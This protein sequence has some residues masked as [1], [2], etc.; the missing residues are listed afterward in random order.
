MAAQ[1]ATVKKSNTVSQP[2]VEAPAAVGI[3]M[4]QDM[5][6][7]KQRVLGKPIESVPVQNSYIPERSD[8]EQGNLF[9]A[10]KPA[11]AQVFAA[12]I[13]PTTYPGA[14]SQINSKP[15][16]NN[17]LSGF[18]HEDQLIED[19]EAQRNIDMNE[20]KNLLG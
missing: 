11:N 7:N 2:V 20:L 8:E 14:T 12:K 3:T 19:Q 16:Y 9:A 1:K 13:A 15:A 6:L 17:V 10:Q 18:V 4:Q 5:A